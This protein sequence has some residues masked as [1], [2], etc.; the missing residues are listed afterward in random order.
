[1][2]NLTSL[3]PPNYKNLEQRGAIAL[4]EK[5]EKV[6]E[7][8]DKQLEIICGELTKVSAENRDLK[9]IGTLFQGKKL[10]REENKAL[11][12]EYLKEIN[13]DMRNRRWVWI[14]V[15]KPFSYEYKTSGYYCVQYDFSRGESFCCGYPGLGF[16]FDYC[17]Y[18]RTWLAYR[19]EVTPLAEES[20]GQNG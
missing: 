11:T 9:H 20:E 19:N 3:F 1:M 6:V 4:L 12:V 16:G 7:E 10:Q 15:L 8:Q 5:I 13:Q 17:D 14:E 18:G 2:N